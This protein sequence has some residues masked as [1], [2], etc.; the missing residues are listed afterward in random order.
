MGIFHLAKFSALVN[1]SILQF[2]GSL[3]VA[4]ASAWFGSWLG[5]RH[6]LRRLRNEKAFERRLVWYEDIV[7]ALVAVRD[8][9]IWYA[10]ATRQRDATL[11]GQLA[12]QLGVAFQTFGDRANK[13]ILYAPTKTV[14]RM[15]S[16]VQDLMA[17]APQFI[18][19]LE[20]GQLYEEYAA[21]VDSLIAALNPLIFELAQ[22]VRGELDIEP[23]ELSD[24]ERKA[25]KP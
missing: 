18:Q 14:R 24:L 16:F 11:L 21:R 8:L 6:A 19:T 7:V 15:G 1:P 10:V 12:P 23:I 17:L 4:G 3:I 13:V 5:V 25:L 9:C 20:A 22:E 2:I